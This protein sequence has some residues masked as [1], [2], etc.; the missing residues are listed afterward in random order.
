[1]TD[2]N[3]TLSVIFLHE[4]G[5]KTP[6][7][8]KRLAEWSIKVSNNRWLDKE[9]VVH[10]YWISNQKTW[11]KEKSGPNIFTGEFNQM[12]RKEST[13]ILTKLF[14]N[15]ENSSQPILWGQYY[16]NTKTKDI[17]RKKRNYTPISILNR[18]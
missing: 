8:R 15:I 16:P 17:M 9:D 1:M 13:S 6:N 14:Q 3:S 18:H 10:I 5:L 11:H 2:I 12:Y 7:E 4:N